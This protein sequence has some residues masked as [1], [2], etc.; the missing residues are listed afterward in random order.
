MPIKSRA[1][2]PATLPATGGLGAPA[3]ERMTLSPAPQG[4]R[5]KVELPPPVRDF[6]DALAAAF[7]HP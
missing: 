4:V 7:I 1:F 5:S 6:H 2:R 3:L